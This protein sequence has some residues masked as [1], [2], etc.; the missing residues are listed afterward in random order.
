MINEF[1]LILSFFTRFPV[2]KINYSEDNFEKAI[3]FTPLVGVV[4]GLSLV[5]VNI[6]LRNIDNKLIIGFILMLTYIVI[7]G[8][9]HLDGLSDSFDG[10]FS[11]RDKERILE[12]MKDSRVGA[13]G[14]ISL[15]I[16]VIGYSIFLG[17]VG[18]V[19]LFSMPIIGRSSLYIA[20]RFSKYGRVAGMGKTFM[21]K[22]NTKGSRNIVI[23]MNL[24]CICLGIF[25]GENLIFISI[26]ITY[27]VVFRIVKFTEGKIDGITGDILGMIVELSQITFLIV[28]YILINI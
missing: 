20:S 7:T 3:K 16:I 15:I 10:L 8:G 1:K 22:G 13:F 5:L 21:E 2:G 6:F 26:V 9:L 25:Y 17:E 19:I 27:F 18:I 24:L 12:I 4:I 14:A 11:G 28:S 23:F